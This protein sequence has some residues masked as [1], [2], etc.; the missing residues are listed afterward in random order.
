MK[1]QA[2]ISL[3]FFSLQFMGCKT[4]QTFAI[5]VVQYPHYANLQIGHS[6]EGIYSPSTPRKQAM[7]A[8]YYA[9]C[10]TADAKRPK[11][12]VASVAPTKNPVSTTPA[13]LSLATK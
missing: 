6:G 9:F 13:L 3:I 1:K 4:A 8:W 10:D 2:L 7:L 5:P 11:Q 12:Q